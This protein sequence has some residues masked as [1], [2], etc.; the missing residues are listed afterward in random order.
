MNSLNQFRPFFRGVELENIY[1]IEVEIA[2]TSGI[3]NGYAYS[4]SFKGAVSELWCRNDD[5]KDQ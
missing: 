1:G 5:D 3:R 4:Y 2:T